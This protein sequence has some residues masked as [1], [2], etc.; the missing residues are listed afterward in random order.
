[1]RAHDFLF[2]RAVIE[3]SEPKGVGCVSAVYVN[4]LLWVNVRVMKDRTPMNFCFRQP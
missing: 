2:L 4:T 1:M 3:I